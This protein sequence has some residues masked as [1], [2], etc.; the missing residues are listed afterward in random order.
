MA[1][2]KA[3]IIRSKT[4]D[5][6]QSPVKIQI[7]HN[8]KTARVTLFWIEPKYFNKGKVSRSHKEFVK[9]N[10]TI[11]RELA[12]YVKRSDE[13]QRKGTPYTVYDIRDKDATDTHL[14]SDVLNAFRKRQKSLNKRTRIYKNIRDRINQ[15]DPKVHIHSVD[16]NWMD[17]FANFL[18]DQENINSE[19][20][21]GNYIKKLKT[22]LRSDLT[23]YFNKAVFDYPIPKSESVIESLTLEEMKRWQNGSIPERLELYRDFFTF[24]VH[25]MG[26]RVSDVL[27]LE[28]GQIRNGYIHFRETK[29]GQRKGTGKVKKV[30]V[31]K[32]L[33]S[34]IDRYQGMSRYYVF[35]LLKRAPSDPRIDDRYQK[36]IESYTT[37]VN[38]K[39][40]LIAAY[41]GITKKVTNHVARHTFASM[42]DDE[43]IDL[44]DIQKMLNHSE[45]KQTMNYIHR[46]RKAKEINRE[47]QKVLGKLEEE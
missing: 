38:N 43:N 10:N 15:F 1:N 23:D 16:K 24:M 35:P 11:N 12:R 8:Y 22:V 20:T 25:C 2:I 4:N 30:A 17:R 33:G 13:L 5:Q 39:L 9:L 47:A 37:V 41:L 29:T 7:N 31:N 44:R 36:H 45:I 27:M 28:P 34:I 46:I 42:A 14:L 32:T 40:R 3:V 18:R 26:E 19:N 6:G 21:V